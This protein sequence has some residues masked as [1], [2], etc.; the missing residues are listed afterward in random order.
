M[1]DS[2]SPVCRPP[3]PVCGQMHPS[4]A[5]MCD[6]PRGHALPHIGPASR[7]DSAPTIEWPTEPPTPR[8]PP[9]HVDRDLISTH[10]RADVR[11][12]GLLDDDEVIALDLGSV[13][14]ADPDRIAGDL[15]TLL[16][17]A[18]RA[19]EPDLPPRQ[20]AEKVLGLDVA[21]PFDVAEHERRYAE[22]VQRVHDKVACAPLGIVAQDTGS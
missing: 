1:N 20:W 14:I 10:V 21:E 3:A 18:L 19:L 6:L 8:T 4:R 9:L 2:T 17:G 5:T 16:R 22:T 15:A 13:S 7:A 11:V 12:I